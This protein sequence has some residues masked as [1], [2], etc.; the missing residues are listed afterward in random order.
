MGPERRLMG[1]NIVKGLPKE[2]K[3]RHRRQRERAEGKGGRASMRE[4]F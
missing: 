3:P 4:F 2:E 1:Q